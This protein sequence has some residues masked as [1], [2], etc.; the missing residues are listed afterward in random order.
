MNTFDSSVTTISLALEAHSYAKRFRQHHA[1]PAK[2]KAVYLNTLAVCAVKT[3]LERS[4]FQPDIEASVCWQPAQQT[5]MDIADLWVPGYGRVECRPVLPNQTEMTV[6]PEVWDGRLCYVAVQLDASLRSAS[7]L[8]FVEAIASQ[9]IA[10]T[11][12]QPLDELM[13]HLLQRPEVQ[14]PVEAT[15]TPSVSAFEPSVKLGQWLQNAVAEGWQT[16]EQLVDMAADGVTPQLAWGFRQE[17]STA[18]VTSQ[19]SS[20]SQPSTI[21]GKQLTLALDND[22]VQVVLMVGLPTD[23]Q[24]DMDIRVQVVPIQPPGQLPANLMLMVLDDTGTS[25]MQAQTRSTEAMQL[26][27]GVD[28]GEVFSL[29]LELEGVSVVESFVV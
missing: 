29:K 12:L 20:L 8:G 26:R 13:P 7:I 18:S 16:I 17:A 2:A 9:K 11:E 14:M 5:L 6:P 19:P 21:R 27:F 25:V 28:P 10:L 23:I 24:P 15:S 4:G 3:Y 1:N 22:E